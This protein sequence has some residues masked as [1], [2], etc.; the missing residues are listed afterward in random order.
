MSSDKFEVLAKDSSLMFFVRIKFIF[1]VFVSL[2]I[3]ENSA[4]F[5]GCRKLIKRK[6]KNITFFGIPEINLK[7]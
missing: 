3:F 5:D 1:L 6:E 4:D 7:I 2:L